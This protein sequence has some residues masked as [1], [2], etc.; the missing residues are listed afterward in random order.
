[1]FLSWKSSIISYI[2]TSAVWCCGT[3]TWSL[4]SSCCGNDKP[5]SEP[6]SAKSGRKRS[7]FLLILTIAIAFAFQYA[8]APRISNIPVTNYVTTSW[9]VGCTDYPLDLQERCIGNHGVYRATCSALLFFLFAG[10][11]AYC[12]PTAN[13]EAWPAKYVLFLFLVL[14]MCFIPNTPWFSP[15][16]L[17]AARIG[18]IVFVVI[19]Q[20]IMLDMAYNWNESWVEKS[21]RAETEQEEKRW[22]GAII[23]SCAALLL[24]SFVGVGY[25]FLK[26]GGCT[27]NNTCIVLTLVFNIIITAFQPFTEEGSLLS[28]S[29]MSVYGTYLCYTALTTNPDISC[30]P[31]IG[32]N[33]VSGIVFGIG[34]SLLSLGW[35]SYSSTAG[36]TNNG[37]EQKFAQTL[38]KNEAPSHTGDFLPKESNRK[39]QGIV[40]TAE[41]YGST[42]EL[43]APSSPEE[44]S[45]SC[46]SWKLNLTL[47]MISCWVAMVLSGWGSIH[48]GSNAANPDVSF[49]SMWLIMASQWIAYLLYIWSLVAPKLFPDRDFS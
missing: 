27:I 42:P 26:F 35:T 21:N 23:A 47:G 4:A 8:L 22:L 44:A 46:V 5:S 17:N 28:S 18:A 11:A 12:K 13:R 36:S 45:T 3:A 7:A 43:E 15:I 37:N 20:V 34:I 49:I 25:L 41:K 33:D 6:P 38:V 31:Q 1:M 16:F 19:Q 10:M 30:N 39:V 2:A 9:K 14:G 32:Q 48:I 29:M 24:S 40:T